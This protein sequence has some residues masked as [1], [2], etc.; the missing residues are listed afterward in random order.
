MHKQVEIKHALGA[1]VVFDE[2]SMIDKDHIMLITKDK[3][4]K[5]EITQARNRI[6]VLQEEVDTLKYR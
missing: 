6:K 5:E 1:M 3:E 2:Q 4:M